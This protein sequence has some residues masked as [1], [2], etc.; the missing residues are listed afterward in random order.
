MHDFVRQYFGGAAYESKALPKAGSNRNYYRLACNHQTYILCENTGVSENETF[1]YYANFFHSHGIPVPEVFAINEDKTAYLLQDVGHESLLD[2]IQREG[3]TDE[4]KWLYQKSLRALVRMQM[5]GAT[6]DD[7]YAFAAHT[8][9]KAMVLADLNYFKYYFLDLQ[10]ESYDKMGLQE[11]FE[12]LA[13]ELSAEVCPY[14]MFRDFQGRNILLLN[15][16][17]YFIDFQGGMKGPLA[18]DVASLLW[19]AKANL[20]TEWRSDLLDDYLQELRKYIPVDES[21]FRQSYSWFVLIRL[22]QVLGAYGRRGII[23]QKQHFLDSI[24]FALQNLQTWL[25]QYPITDY[26]L[27]GRCMVQLIEREAPKS[28]PSIEPI[29]SPLIIRVQSFSYKK[30]MPVDETGNGGGFVF[31]CRGILNP[32]RFAEYKALTGRDQPVID[33]L[34]SKT[35]IAEF[36]QAAYQAVDI[37]VEDYRQRNFENLSISFGCTGGQ[38]RSVYCAD[39][40]AKHLQEKYNAHVVLCHIEQEAKNWQNGI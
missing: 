7:R 28:N 26:P 22:L 5:V 38:H 30:G 34:V 16:E 17:P 2:R 15:N 21:K 32:G 37:S 8:F 40:M 18:Y 1:L 23:E 11:E 13:T 27:L 6:L 20:S 29:E 33:F 24:P 25:H 10:I 9:D 3:Q 12:R 39:A 4:V 36:L 35:R 19:Q 14:F 31:D